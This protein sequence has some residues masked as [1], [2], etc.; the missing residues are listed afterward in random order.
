MCKI[1]RWEAGGVGAVAEAAQDFGYFP[2]DR[3]EVW[4]ACESDSQLR[5]S[6]PIP[7]VD[8]VHGYVLREVKPHVEDAWDPQLIFD[9]VRDRYLWLNVG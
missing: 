6:E 8:P 4:V 7:L 2:G 5:D 3:P 1:E 9:E